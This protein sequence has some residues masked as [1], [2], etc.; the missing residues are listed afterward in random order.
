MHRAIAYLYVPAAE[1]EKACDR[2][3]ERRYQRIQAQREVEIQKAMNRWIF[4]C[5]TRESAVRWLSASRWSK[6]S[7]LATQDATKL[8]SVIGARIAAR[9]ALSQSE[10]MIVS[11]ELA[12]TLWREFTDL[13]VH[14]RKVD[15]AA[16]AAM[17]NSF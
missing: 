2:W 6:Y 14:G 8:E 11:S 4:P 3:I 1:I 7:L 17:F 12:Y 5:S 9:Q 15:R 16:E 13:D 10:P